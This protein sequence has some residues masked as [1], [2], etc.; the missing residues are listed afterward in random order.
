M[1]KRFLKDTMRFETPRECLEFQLNGTRACM[2]K[3]D[4][5]G[6]CS[7]YILGDADTITVPSNEMLKIAL[8]HFEKYGEV[9]FDAFLDNDRSDIV[10]IG[11]WD[12]NA[13]YSKTVVNRQIAMLEEERESYKKMTENGELT[14]EDE[15]I[16][17]EILKE[18]EKMI[19]G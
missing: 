13:T 9:E 3:F 2:Y 15:E 4:K 8:E 6:V 7:T 1:V 14:K 10:T 16:W 5:Y 19:Y 17:L 18:K 11:C 12:E